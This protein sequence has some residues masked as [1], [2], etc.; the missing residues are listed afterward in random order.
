MRVFFALI[1]CMALGSAVAVRPAVAA[2][3]YDLN[4]IL[5]L[6]GQ[7]AFIGKSMQDML[8][9]FQ[10]AFNKRSTI[11]GR[12]L[13]FVFSDDQTAPQVSVQLA[14]AL[15][16]KN[17]PVFLGPSITGTCKAVV[18][19]VTKGPVEYC[20]SPGIQPAKN[21][22][23]YS[24]SISSDDLVGVGLKYF[25]ERGWHRIARLTTTD[26]TGQ[27]ADDA[28]TKWLALPENK[29]LTVV[30]DEHFAI[31]DISTTAQMSRIK[32][33][34]PQVVVI[35]ATGSPMGTAL[36]AYAD[37]G[38][39]LPVFVTNSNMTTVQM[40]QYSSLLPKGYFSAAP[41]YVAG[42]AQTPAS[43][44][45]MDE[46]LASLVTATIPN[47]F[48]SGITWDA[49]KVVTD[50]LQKIGPNATPDQIRAFI[51]QLSKYPG[52]AGTYNYSDGS[53]R[54]LSDKDL[55]VMRY[56]TTAQNWV[57]MSNF[58]GIPKR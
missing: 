54:G 35:W 6:S 13:H 29:A 31:G 34:Q 12:P 36:R 21:S 23:T 16:A 32:A 26:A 5:S 39:D 53:Q 3:P 7:G 27:L 9:A 20:L 47:D 4:V 49:A 17:V 57:S 50:A 52:I 11:G 22:Y 56:D 33:A 25:R 40:K 38:L 51:Q 8:T 55:M 37:T 42:V 58:G 28:F 30:A 15:I 41:G 14:N 1:L 18:P 2:D 24:V 46:Y 43:K 10:T 48:I 45:A 44:R 19:L